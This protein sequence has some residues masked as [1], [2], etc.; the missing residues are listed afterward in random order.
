RQRRLPPLALPRPLR[1][2]DDLVDEAGRG[3]VELTGLR[4]RRRVVDGRGALRGALPGG[5]GAEVRDTGDG[6]HGACLA[7][8]PPA[9]TGA[10][11]HPVGRSPRTTL[12]TR[13][14]G[15]SKMPLPGLL[16]G[17]VAGRA[18]GLVPSLLSLGLRLGGAVLVLE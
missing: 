9:T 2:R 18:A 1:H 15:L 11:D 5:A 12:R 8:H 4:T 17:P 16:H 7:G 10:G 13:P 6:A 3:E 14:H